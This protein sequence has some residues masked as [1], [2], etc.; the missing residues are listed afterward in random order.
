[1]LIFCLSESSW[2]SGHHYWS[3]DI[4]HY[5]NVARWIRRQTC[6][7]ILHLITVS[8]LFQNLMV[9]KVLEE[10]DLA[11][12][13]LES[14]WEIPLAHFLCLGLSKRRKFVGCI[15]PQCKTKYEYNYKKTKQI[16]IYSLV[17]R[18]SWKR[19]ETSENWG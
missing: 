17:E 19:S 18:K 3:W 11:R 15:F 5:K 12:E 2:Y 16:K 1:M 6:S 13:T 4:F 9:K 7:S 10:V 14:F 8:I